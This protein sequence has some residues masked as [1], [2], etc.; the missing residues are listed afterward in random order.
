MDETREWSKDEWDMPYGMMAM[1]PKIR[2]AVDD[3][4]ASAASNLSADVKHEISTV[5][6]KI[7]LKVACLRAHDIAE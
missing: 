2:E 3:A 6:D 4:L 5:G 7:G 1:T